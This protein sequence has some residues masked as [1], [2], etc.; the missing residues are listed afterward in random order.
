MSIWLLS[1]NIITTITVGA[2]RVRPQ[3]TKT[4]FNLFKN[5]FKFNGCKL[6]IVVGR[7]L[8]PAVLIKSDFKTTKTSP[9]ESFSKIYL[10]CAM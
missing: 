1:Y 2:H 3:Q 7:G 4:K 6:H 9:L 5:L 8:A 10:L